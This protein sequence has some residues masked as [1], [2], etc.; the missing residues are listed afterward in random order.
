MK[1]I[2]GKI[3]KLRRDTEEVSDEDNVL[4]SKMT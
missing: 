4:E 2:K 3:R 1:E